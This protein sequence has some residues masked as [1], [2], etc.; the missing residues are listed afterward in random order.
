VVC[1]YDGAAE[2]GRRSRNTA[3]EAAD[4]EVVVKMIPRG[5]RLAAI[6]AAWGDT[7]NRAVLLSGKEMM[8]N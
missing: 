1:T 4:S 6:E 3:E 8:T 2:E 7:K 5:V